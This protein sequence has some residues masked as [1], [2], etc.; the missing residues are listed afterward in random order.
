M[1]IRYREPHPGPCPTAL[2]TLAI[3]EHRE[4]K[5]KLAA[6]ERLEMIYWTLKYSCEQA[7]QFDRDRY[8]ELE[9][10]GR[11]ARDELL[12]LIGRE[13]DALRTL[14]AKLIEDNHLDLLQATYRL[15]F[16]ASDD[17]KLLHR[18]EEDLKRGLTRTMKELRDRRREA[19]KSIQDD[20]LQ[21]VMDQTDPEVAP[22]AERATP[23]IEANPGGDDASKRVIEM[24]ETGSFSAGKLRKNE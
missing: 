12:W 10:N 21:D 3:A 18:Y 14:K 22:S 7:H 13:V 24:G 8:P 20:S 2:C 11:G 15:R 17:G 5:A 4:V 9:S 23:R 19:E 6:N 1:G 16:D